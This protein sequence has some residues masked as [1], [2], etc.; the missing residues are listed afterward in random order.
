MDA[1]RAAKELAAL[2]EK[3]AQRLRVPVT[4]CAIDVHGE[5]ILKQRITGAKPSR[6][7][8]RSEKHTRLRRST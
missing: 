3:E 1:L 7:K 4:F 5:V 2:V 6:S 8:C